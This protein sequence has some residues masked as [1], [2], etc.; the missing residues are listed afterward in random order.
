MRARFGF[1]GA[2]AGPGFVSWSTRTVMWQ[3][4]LKMAVTRPRARER[5]RFS[6][7][8]ES[9]NHNHWPKDL[10][11]HQSRIVLYPIYKCW[12]EVAI[13]SSWFLATKYE[14][15]AGFTN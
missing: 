13:I 14:F 5:Q 1:S 4:R 12:L 15:L 6:V 3:V 7:G 9:F 11:L 2:D 8:L 10:L